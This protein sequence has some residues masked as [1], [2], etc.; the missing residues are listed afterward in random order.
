MLEE[1]DNLGGGLSVV[2]EASGRVRSCFE[3]FS[4]G[5]WSLPLSPRE[6]ACSGVGKSPPTPFGTVYV[7]RGESLGWRFVSVRLISLFTYLVVH[8]V[9]SSSF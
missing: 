3:G 2:I 7:R 4:R 1:E 6:G 5:E 9:L 8:A